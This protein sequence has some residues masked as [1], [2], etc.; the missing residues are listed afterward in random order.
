MV[1]KPRKLPAMVWTQVFSSWRRRLTDQ[2]YVAPLLGIMATGGIMAVRGM[3]LLQVWELHTFDWM[4]NH[5][6]AE[7]PDERVVIIG[8]G[9]DDIMRYN[10]ADISDSM[11]ANVIEA[12]KKQNPTVI[13]MDFFRNVPRDEGYPRLQ[14]IFEETP[15]LIGIEKVVDDAALSSVSGNSVLSRKQ[16]VAASDL[17]VDVDG[18]VR[19]GFLFPSASGDRVIE[20]LAFRVAL[21]YLESH[22]IEPN[23]NAD[24]LELGYARMPP[25]EAN[26]GGYNQADAGGYQLIMNWRA[27]LKIK[28]FS[29][30]D[31]L[32]GN[33]PPG[34]LRDKIVLMGSMQS[35][36]ADVF[37]TPYS[38]RKGSIGLLPSHGIEI[39][40]S[41]ASQII[42]S[43]F[44]QRPLIHTLSEPMEVVLIA[45]SAGIGIGLYR[46]G[47]NDF[48]R[49]KL[50]GV[51]WVGAFGVSYAALM[52]AGWWL[53]VVPVSLSLLAAPVITRLQKINR[54]QTLSQVDEL[55]Q[56]ANRRSFQEHLVQEWQRGMRSHTPLSLIICDVD[57]FKLYNDT[58]G[59]PQGD[60][61]LRQVARAIGQAVRRPDDL[62]V[63]YGGEEF[64]ILLPNTTSEGAQQVAKDAAENVFALK[65]EHKASQVSPYVSI[66]LGVTTITPEPDVAISTLV[67]T[68]DLGLYEAKRRGRNQMVVR[69]PWTVG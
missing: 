61:C 17:I 31:V 8:F 7:P 26:S 67:D 58:Y 6:L 32:E 33:L 41:L 64:V 9:G 30:K 18:R 22:D 25:F 55:T 39:H 51:C 13:G 15:N 23:P 43:A 27:N 44:G 14:Q 63:R 3:G 42:S 50:F 48:H 11:L 36:D 60:E 5:R 1:D 46:L 56:L 34:I 40:A 10:S 65:L 16:Q 69:L 2:K 45:V 19:R 12:V 68:A 37:F 20:G 29:V 24:V 52:F 4:M 35:G 59:H 53:P 57:Y 28:T 54:L 62:A 21:E 66:S 49:L 47:K 38:H